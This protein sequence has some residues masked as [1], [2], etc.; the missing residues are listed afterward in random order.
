MLD[1]SKRQGQMIADDV[2]QLP[3]KITLKYWANVEENGQVKPVE[4][5]RTV[6]G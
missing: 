4:K 3:S 5:T 6:S 1:A 2:H